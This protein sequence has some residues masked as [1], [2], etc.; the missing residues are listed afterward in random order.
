MKPL[1]CQ[2]A[3]QR[4]TAEHVRLHQNLGCGLW[5]LLIVLNIT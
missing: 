2:T 1:K 3:E 4:N 5:N